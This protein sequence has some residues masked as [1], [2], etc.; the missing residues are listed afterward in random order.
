MRATT[1]KLTWFSVINSTAVVTEHSP[2]LSFMQKR[3]KAEIDNFVSYR[4]LEGENQ[5][6]WEKETKGCG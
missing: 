1:R 3:R 2:I 6:E 4:C 5:F